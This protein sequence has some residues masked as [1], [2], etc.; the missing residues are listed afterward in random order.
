MRTLSKTSRGAN[1]NDYTLSGGAERDE[2]L[3]LDRTTVRTL[4]LGVSHGPEHERRP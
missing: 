4:D 2:H 3:L 1:V